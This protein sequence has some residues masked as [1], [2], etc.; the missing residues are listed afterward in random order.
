MIGP[1]STR[2]GTVRAWGHGHHAPTYRTGRGP[3]TWASSP[4]SPRPPRS[5]RTTPFAP[6]AAAAASTSPGPA[7]GW[8]VKPFHRQHP[9]RGFFGDPRIGMTPKG[10][11][12]QLPLR[13][14]R[15]VPQRHAQVYATLDGIVRARVL[16]TGDGRGRRPR[17][18]HGVPVLAHQPRRPERSARHRLPHGRRLGGAAV[19]ARPLR[20]APRRRLRQPAPPRRARAVRRHDAALGQ[21]ASRRGGRPPGARHGGDAARSTSSSRRTTRRRSPS[22]AA[23]AASPSRPRSSAGG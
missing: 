18:P 16:P 22:P 3:W 2:F 19:G 7:Y 11:Q 12:T 9:V 23:G 1:W 17:R 14:R 13:H 8:P 20:R 10:M 5:S 21:A 4:A 6:D 15:L